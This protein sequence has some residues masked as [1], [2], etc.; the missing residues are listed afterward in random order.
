[1]IVVGMHHGVCVLSTE[2]KVTGSTTRKGTSESSWP[3]SVCHLWGKQGHK[4][5]RNGQWNQTVAGTGGVTRLFLQFKFVHNLEA[6]L[7]NRNRPQ[8][9][10]LTRSTLLPNA[11]AT[12]YS[13]HRLI[14]SAGLG[15]ELQTFDGAIRDYV[16]SSIK[17]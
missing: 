13:A 17:Y 4:V 16:A 10:R 8:A 14:C 12:I 1:M 3:P 5:S 15:S 6:W 2:S 7:Q 9:W 11:P